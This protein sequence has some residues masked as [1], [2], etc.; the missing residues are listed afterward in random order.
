MEC[1]NRLKDPCVADFVEGVKFLRMEVDFKD[2]APGRIRTPGQEL[3]RLLLY[4]TE[5]QAHKVHI[6]QQD[7]KS[8]EM[9]FRVFTSQPG[10]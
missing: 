3:R 4:P 5:L 7:A 9:N 6:N 1:P 8:K 2:G 10:Y